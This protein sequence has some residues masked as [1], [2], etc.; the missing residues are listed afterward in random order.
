[1]CEPIAGTNRNVTTDNW[2]TSIN[3]AEMFFLE[4]KLTLVGTIR[5]NRLGVP[6]DFKANKKRELHSSIFAHHKEKTLVLY[7]TKKNKVVVLVST[8]HSD[9]KVDPVSGESCKQQI[10]SFYNKTK[11]GVDSVDQMCAKYDCPRNTKRW[12]MVVFF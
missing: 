8:M 5:A 7:R 6:E 1:M 3:L 9:Q 2:F 12:P 10:V 11:V 4:K